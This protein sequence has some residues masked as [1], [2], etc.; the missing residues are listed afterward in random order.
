MFKKIGIIGGSGNVGSHIAFLA[1]MR[2][3]AKRIIVHSIDIPRC[4]GVSLDVSQAACILNLPTQVESCET[5]EGLKDCEVIIMSAGLPRTPNMTREDLLLKNAQ[6]LKDTMREIATIA[7]DSFI[8]VV[9][10][11]LDVM[12]YVAKQ[13]SAFPKER[14]IGMAGVLDSARLGYEI[15]Q[16]LADYHTS[17][18]PLV[19]GGHGDDM[20]PLTRYSLV[21]DKTLDEIFD[22]QTLSHIIKE[23]KNGGA[24]IVNYYQRGSAYFAPATAVIKMLEVI[25]YDSQE[26]LSCSVYLEGEYGLNDLC[27]GVPVKLGKKGVVQIV[28]LNLS[29]Q[30]QERLNIS[31][32]GIRKQIK[33]LADNHL[34]D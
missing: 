23:T 25:L 28:T 29:Q 22:E 6:I 5:L 2:G 1:A 21:N 7:P 17:V 30:E 10:N 31:A 13:I 18:S 32:E 3:I 12:T 33:I 4:K 15:K 26:V 9:S 14:I 16:S 34:F 11:P 27:M 24:K 8:I 20:L 19:I